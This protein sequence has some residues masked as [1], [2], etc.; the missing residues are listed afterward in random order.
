MHIL[1][2]Q[3]ILTIKPVYRYLYQF[4]HSP[5][6]QSEPKR[7][8]IEKQ[9][10]KRGVYFLK[11]SFQSHRYVC[12]KQIY[13]ALFFLRFIFL[14]LC[15]RRAKRKWQVGE[16]LCVE[17]LYKFQVLIY[18]FINFILNGILICWTF[19]K[20]Y[21]MCLLL[22]LYKCVKFSVLLMRI[23]LSKNLNSTWHTFWEYL[24]IK[25]DNF[26]LFIWHNFSMIFWKCLHWINL[27]NRYCFISYCFLM[28]YLRKNCLFFHLIW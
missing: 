27:S 18:F 16:E 23:R 24:L 12:L 19:D 4:L 20:N 8:Y 5:N 3:N 9:I 6:H 7:G 17:L 22:S 25:N 15:N 28:L 26:H 1:R 11:I 14:F 21:L 10:I 13:M 2:R